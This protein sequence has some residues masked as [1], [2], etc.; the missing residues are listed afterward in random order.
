MTVVSRRHPVRVGDRPIVQPVGVA[1]VSAD[2]D[3]SVGERIRVGAQRRCRRRVA[4][5]RHRRGVVGGVVAV[6]RQ[7]HR[8]AL[9]RRDRRR[10]V[11]LR[12]VDLVLAGVLVVGDEPLEPLAPHDLAWHVGGAR[13]RRHAGALDDALEDHDQLELLALQVGGGHVPER[14]RVR[15]AVLE[16]H[17]PDE[18]EAVVI[19]GLA[20][21]QLVLAERHHLALGRRPAADQQR[22]HMRLDDVRLAH[23][24]DAEQQAEVAVALAHHRRLAE[25]Q[26]LGA[27][28]RPRDL[29]ED[30]ARHQRLDDDAEARLEHHDED[31]LGAV[32]RHLPAAVADRVLRLDGEEERRGE[33]GH[34]VDARRPARLAGVRQVAMREADQ[35]PDERE[36]QPAEHECQHE[37][38]QV[39][40][41]L[42]VDE[43]REDVGEVALPPLLDVVVRHVVVAVLADEPTV[44]P[45]REPAVAVQAQ[46]EVVRRARQL[47]RVLAQRVA[48]ELE[49]AA[50]EERPRAHRGA[51]G[52]WR[53]RWRGRERRLGQRAPARGHQAYLRH[54]PTASIAERQLQRARFHEPASTADTLSLPVLRTQSLTFSPSHQTTHK[55]TPVTYICT[56]TT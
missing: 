15:D 52:G 45:L 55:S 42:D 17:R 38:E 47:R 36:Q 23:V 39:P 35:P 24:A 13:L 3:G 26:R 22:A 21:L 34:L 46:R 54:R 12:V 28:L 8:A 56:R 48:R 7:H 50:A 18:E 4:A 44:R 30:E 43:R 51:G 41:P 5:R 9:R 14:A 40:A 37:D 2:D 1:I 32:R 25:H 49:R 16:D 20:E 11:E 53:G 29:R 19:G 10:R 27:L 31:R 33:V 6:A